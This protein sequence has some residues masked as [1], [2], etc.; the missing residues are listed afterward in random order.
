MFPPSR[1]LKGPAGTGL[2]NPRSKR[3]GGDGRSC[4]ARRTEGE[5]GGP[6]PTRDK[7]WRGGVEPARASFAQGLGGHPA[8]LA[9]ASEQDGGAEGNRTPDLCSAIAALSHLSYCRGQAKRLLSVPNTATQRPLE[10]GRNRRVRPPCHLRPGSSAPA[11]HR[12][13]SRT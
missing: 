6:T 9:L 12:R 7:L 13:R 10:I 11:P 4:P 5:I 3:T 2:Q 1:V 8:Q